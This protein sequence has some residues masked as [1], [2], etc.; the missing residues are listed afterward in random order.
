MK[1]L[2]NLERALVQDSTEKIFAPLKN[3]GGKRKQKEKP[4]YDPHNHKLKEI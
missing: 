1:K 2:I 4:H 3:G